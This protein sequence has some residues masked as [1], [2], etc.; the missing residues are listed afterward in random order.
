MLNT[1]TTRT[2]GTIAALAAMGCSSG[3]GSKGGTDAGIGGASGSGGF[4]AFGAFGGAS[5]AG[6]TGGAAGA[7]A[8]GGSDAGSAASGGI[9]GGTGG[10]AGSAGSAA[11]G[12]VGNTGGSGGT[13]GG[14]LGVSENVSLA[15]GTSQCLAAWHRSGSLY[16]SKLD[17][18]AKPA[19]AELFQPALPG[20]INTKTDYVAAEGNTLY[21]LHETQSGSTLHTSLV[22]VA[23]ASSVKLLPTQSLTG[24]GS[25]SETRL[26]WAH[27][28]GMVSYRY[29]NSSFGSSPGVGFLSAAGSWLGG[30]ENFPYTTG[31]N[32][33]PFA[34][35]VSD[36]FVMRWDADD[37]V[38]PP[39]CGWAK[40]S[41]TG[42]T[43]S[44]NCPSSPANTTVY[45]LRSHGG[46][47][48]SLTTLASLLHLRGD[49][50]DGTPIVSVSGIDKQARYLAVNAT[51]AWTIT[52]AGSVDRYDLA[53]KTKTGTLTLPSPGSPVGGTAVALLPDRVVVA[54][55]PANNPSYSAIVSSFPIASMSETD[56]VSDVIP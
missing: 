44:I 16:G 11:S 52:Y 10:G 22:T 45:A 7:A 34:A 17:S 26:S 55:I 32:F 50:L 48:Y 30:Q 49:A 35:A 29:F 41:K 37:G 5:G 9:G 4:G 15:C 28:R 38:F 43:A 42:G 31:F 21:A 36:G 12:G 1:K 46:I 23:G 33:G 53:T 3:G 25:I 20:T 54:R 18:K 14:A 39:D 27:G 8:S 13:G 40:F 6:A 24:G 47:A 2:L 19:A 56:I 51:H